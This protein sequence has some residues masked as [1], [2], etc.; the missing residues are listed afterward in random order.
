MTAVNL[1]DRCQVVAQAPAIK[2]SLPGGAVLQASAGMEKGAAIAVVRPFLSMISGA[3]AFLAPAFTALEVGTAALEAIASVPKIVTQ[4]QKLLEA[5]AKLAE[6]TPKLLSLAPQFSVPPLVRDILRTV[7]ITLRAFSEELTSII[8]QDAE[9]EA[10]AELAATLDLPQL[11]ASIECAR[12]ESV[13][14][15]ANLSA[16]LG[17]VN[18]L[19]DFV[20]ALVALLPVPIEIPTL[21]SPG[22]NAQDTLAVLGT[23]ADTLDA[24]ADTIPE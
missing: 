13:A 12:G 18:T 21:D 23:V 11:T 3:T 10:T 19:L 20:R 8:E 22:E 17:P 14:A 7:A 5:L 9:I 6:L 15:K 16:S 1:S 2:I 24:I 4:P